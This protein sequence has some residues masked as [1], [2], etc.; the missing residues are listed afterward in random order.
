MTEEPTGFSL[1][2]SGSML[3][4]ALAVFY[5]GRA[6]WIVRHEWSQCRTDTKVLYLLVAPIL[7][8][9]VDVLS[10]TDRL[11]WSRTSKVQPARKRV[12]HAVGPLRPKTA[13]R[14]DG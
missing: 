3:L 4:A 11:F 10:V 7:T 2:L 1:L 6:L 13:M 12:A 14:S 5:V 8:L 9:A